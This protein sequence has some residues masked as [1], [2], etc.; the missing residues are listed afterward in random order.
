[1][2]VTLDNNC[3]NK[4]YFLLLIYLNVLLQKSCFQQ[5]LL[6]TNISQGSVATH[7]RFSGIFS[8]KIRRNSIQWPQ[9]TG[10]LFL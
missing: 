1:V 9:K 3:G 4:H 5:L 7:L 10:T 2:P 6:D 8:D